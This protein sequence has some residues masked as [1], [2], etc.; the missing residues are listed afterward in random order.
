M[1]Y[2]SAIHGFAG[3]YYIILSACEINDPRED[4]KIKAITKE[5][6]VCICS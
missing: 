1:T 3:Q 4:E 2:H 6:I 5:R